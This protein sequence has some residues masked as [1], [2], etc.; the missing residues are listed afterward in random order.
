MPE[1][2]LVGLLRGD[3]REPRARPKQGETLHGDMSHL[4]TR[5]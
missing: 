2:E 5:L 4:T 1:Q 3:G